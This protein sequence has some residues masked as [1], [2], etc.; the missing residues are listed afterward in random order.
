MQIETENLDIFA[1]TDLRA[2]GHSPEALIVRDFARDAAELAPRTV[3]RRKKTGTAPK[4][5][6]AWQD[7]EVAN[8]KKSAE[9]RE[10][11]NMKKWCDLVRRPEGATSKELRA[12]TNGFA[13]IT[14]TMRRLRAMGYTVTWEPEGRGKRYYAYSP[15]AEPKKTEPNQKTE[16]SEPKKTKSSQNKGSR[17]RKSRNTSNRK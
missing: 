4:G 12:E 8:E 11:T 15:E 9:P 17:T 10:G 14:D 3:K 1:T 2:I 7:Q 16:A 5:E 13:L 6:P